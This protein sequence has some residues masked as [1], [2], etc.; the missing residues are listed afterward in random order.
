MEKLLVEFARHADRTRFD[1]RFVSLTTRGPVAEELEALGWPVAALNIPSGL[2]PGLVWRLASCFREW[3]T[4]IVH[5]H[6]TKP[7]IYAAPAARLAG[8]H[9]IIHT[10]HGQR[11]NASRGQNTL[12][13]WSARLAH[14]AV[15]VSHDSAACSR[16][17][18]LAP[19]KVHTIWNGIDTRRFTCRGSVAGGPAVMVGR[20]SREKNVETLFD[21][22]ALVAAQEPGYRLEIAGDGACLAALRRQATALK[23]ENVVTFLGNVRDVP[24]LLQRASMCV[25][26]SL[27]EGISLTL[28]EAMS[29][30]LP[31][32]ATQVGG[33]PEIVADGITG[34]LVPPRDPQML[35]EAMLHLW[36]SPADRMR[37]GI[38]GAIR[39]R[40]Y[41]DVRRMVAQYERLY[42]GRRPAQDSPMGL[43]LP[44]LH[45]S[46]SIG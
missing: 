12:F 24:Q 43:A 36:R 5:A 40:E 26:S 9:K 21:A 14:A 44:S 10:R 4:D 32:I 22:A 1:L 3:R 31:I 27:T 18:G 45:Q 2:R 11:M 29:S 19:S 35:A 28:L 46:A 25:L 30:G 39:V 13:R 33:N 37:M 7:L 34:L 42:I 41:F 17:E 20:L 6:N 15:C 16:A 23:L 38:A 8:V